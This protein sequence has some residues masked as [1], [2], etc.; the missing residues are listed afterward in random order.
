M[1][2]N[3][4]NEFVALFHYPI[5]TYYRTKNA[6]REDIIKDKKNYFQKWTERKYSGIKLHTVSVNHKRKE[7]KIKIVFEYILKNG[8]KELTGVSRHLLTLREIGGKLLITKVELA[9]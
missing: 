9:N 7:I 4:P 1:Q 3:N 2:H 6:T 8:V 5:V